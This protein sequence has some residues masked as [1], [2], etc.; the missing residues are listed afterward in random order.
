M[1]TLRKAQLL[2]VVEMAIRESEW[3]FLYLSAA[4]LHPARY[5]FYRDGRSHRVRVY[6]WNLTP[7]GQNRPADEWRIQATGVGRFE[8]EPHGKTLILGWQDEWEVFAGF[9]VTRHQTALGVSPSFQLREGALRQAVINGFAPHNKGNNE[10]AIAFRPDFLAS[11]VANLESL[12]DCGHVAAEIDM[13][14]RIAR[15]PEQVHDD[16]VA[17]EIA[18]PRRYAV[19][20]T[21]RALREV[22]FRRRV[23]TAYSQSC[24]MCGVQLR[25]LDGAHILPAEHPDSTD[26]THNGVALCPLHHRAF[27][28]AFVTFDPEFQIHVNQDT[29]AQLRQTNLAGGL[30][31][32]ENALRPMLALPPDR[33][34]HPSPHFVNMAN[35]HRG[36]HL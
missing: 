20:S 3:G 35:A 27:D 9:D 19:I 24:A 2:D 25:L 34:D 32:F 23:L 10:L 7:G 1:P 17:E 26:G 16:E 5:Q 21:K 31:G 4:G 8:P 30:D 33:R 11:Y 14:S 29:V 15:D 12:H 13:L 6:I 36:W 18:E 22:S 28:R